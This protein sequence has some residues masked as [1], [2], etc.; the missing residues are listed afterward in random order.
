M[1][2]YNE[3]AKSALLRIDEENKR[4]IK[5]KKTLKRTLV[6]TLSLCLAAAV[7]FG[8]METLPKKA[9]PEIEESYYVEYENTIDTDGN[10]MTGL[11]TE[12]TTGNSTKPDNSNGS[13]AMQ[14]SAPQN[15]EETTEEPCIRF[16]DITYEG[17]T[18]IEK[19][20][21]DMTLYEKDELLGSTTDFNGYFKNKKTKGNVF[22]VKD[23]SE[24]LIIELDG[25]KE[26]LL[27]EVD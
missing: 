12:A 20:S 5:R 19:Y 6:P 9:S 17:K 14:S 25:G 7:C 10:N 23:N 1:K 2:S 13:P 27:K 4:L 16:V 3:M 26:I 15:I 24:F 11:K 22:T 8:V 18:Y 21:E